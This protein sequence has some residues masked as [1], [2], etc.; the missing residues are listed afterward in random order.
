[1][2]ESRD[3][4]QPDDLTGLLHLSEMVIVVPV[5]QSPLLIADEGRKAGLSSAAQAERTPVMR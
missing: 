4:T 1:L 2:N 5:H 3:I